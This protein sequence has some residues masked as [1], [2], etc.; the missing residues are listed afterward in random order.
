MTKSKVFGVNFGDV[1]DRAAENYPNAESII[2]G[3]KRVTYFQLKERVDNLAKGLIKL[4]I[5]AGDH[6]AFWM[7]NCLEL[8]YS[9][10]AIAKAG[11]VIVP[12]S[13]RYKSFELEYILNHSDVKALFMT[14]RFF[15][16]DFM[17]IFRSVCPEVSHSEPGKVECAKFPYLKNIIISGERSYE[18]CFDFDHVMKM[19]EEAETGL[20]SDRHS[21]LDPDRPAIMFY[22]TGTTGLPKGCLISYGSIYF[23]CNNTAHFMGYTDKD[24]LL[25]TSPYFHI[26]GMT[27]FLVPSVLKGACQVLM[28][29]FTAEEA[30][31]LIQKEKITV[32]NGTPTMF[33]L[34]FERPDFGKFDLSSLR[35]GMVGAAAC[36]PDVMKRIIDDRKGM[37]MEAIN[38]Y[39]QSECGGGITFTDFGDSIKRR[40][41]TVGKA[42]PGVKIEIRDPNTEERLKPGERGEMWVKSEGNTLGYYK[43]PEATAERFKNGWLRTGDLAIADE[44]GY[45]TLTGRVSDTIIVGGF[46]V[47]PREIEE[48]LLT[49]EKIQDV[50]ILGVP[51]K[52]L[53]E[54]PAAFIVLKK[55]ERMT[56]E[57]L[58]DFCKERVANFKIPKYV[59]FVDELPY[60]G[61][62]KVQ[63]FKLRDI[64]VK[65]YKIEE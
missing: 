3:E 57:D 5:K 35:I 64:I 51:E 26:F 11:G 53:G 32:F 29:R 19:G 60:I 22:T 21:S 15:D 39:G 2:Y 54:V 7:P 56:E 45:L 42:M 14:D 10:F 52:K 65:K 38:A 50:S 62:G 4:G 33:I 59:D 25:S 58:T 16:I 34:C 41:S 13:S 23:I 48:F 18:G 9:V 36:S 30:L 55:G 40:T 8:L 47:Y 43:N 24:V 17:S 12:I 49:H 27:V 1:L 31:E 63:K 20:L 61:V 6:I 44:H 46:N 28:D 37:G